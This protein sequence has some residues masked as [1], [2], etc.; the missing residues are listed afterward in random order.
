ML[1]GSAIAFVANGSRR[2]ADFHVEQFVGVSEDRGEPL[3]F[4]DEEAEVAVFGPEAFELDEHAVDA[5]LVLELA[6]AVLEGFVVQEDDV[7][8]RKLLTGLPCHPQIHLPHKAHVQQ[9]DLLAA[10]DRLDL[11]LGT[12]GHCILR[13]VAYRLEPDLDASV[14]L[15]KFDLALLSARLLLD[16]H[17]VVLAVQPDQLHRRQSYRQ[18]IVLHLLHLS[19]INV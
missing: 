8:L 15:V 12:F 5:K 3:S 10:H 13:L 19:Q 9:L 17:E 1:D 18:L 4:A 2:A 7:G 14:D 16:F 11:L 6:A